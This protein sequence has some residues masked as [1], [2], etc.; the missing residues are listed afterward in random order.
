MGAIPRTG[1]ISRTAAWCE[2]LDVGRRHA[3]AGDLLVAGD[4][5]EQ[6]SRPVSDPSSTSSRRSPA[7][8]V[9][10]RH[11]IARSMATICRGPCK[12][13]DPSPRHTLFYYAS[14][15]SGVLSAVRRDAY[16]A[17]FVVPATAGA[18]SAATAAPQ[19]YNLDQDPSEKFDLAAKRGED[20]RR[21]AF[22]CRRARENGR[23]RSRT[24]SRPAHRARARVHERSGRGGCLWG[25]SPG[26]SR[27]QAGGA[28]ID[29]R[30]CARGARKSGDTT[31]RCSSCSC[32]Q[33]GASARE[34]TGRH[35]VDSGRRVLDG[36]RRAAGCQTLC[37]CISSRLRDSG[38]TSTPVTNA[39]FER[40]V[41]ATKYVT[42]AERKPDPKDFPGVPLDKLVPGS[43]VFTPPA[44]PVPLDDFSRWWSYVPG[45][46]WR[47]PTAPRVRLKGLE[48]HPVVHI[49]F[50]DAVAY[51]KW[52]GQAVADRSG[53]RVRSARRS[54]SQSVSVG[55]RAQAW[56]EGPRQHL[57]RALPRCEQS[58]GWLSS[59]RR[60]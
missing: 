1:W 24:R 56:R 27:L 33:P 55:Q 48:H 31:S 47:H 6:P 45:A 53:V 5:Q 28:R 11:R 41:R 36:M 37:R 40:F 8:P 18:A 52:A 19:L 15:G 35:G 44:Q 50:E 43:I 13:G 4:D 10:S 29:P 7:S 30:R 23:R 34:F 14:T 58:R 17:F 26:R 51:A 32:A 3:R 54:R 16:K 2:R 20:R 22:A 25:R 42:V 38:W 46:N 49:A 39:E 12:R 60:R 9:S 57:G 21:T 59:E